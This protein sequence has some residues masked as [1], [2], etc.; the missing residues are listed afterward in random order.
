[1]RARLFV[2]GLALP[3]LLACPG[4]L[5]DPERFLTGGDAGGMACD[6]ENDI[7]K[8][9]CGTAGCHDAT[10]V[11]QGLDLA[12]TGVKTRLGSQLATCTS[13]AG[14]PLAAF[15]LVKVKPNPTCGGPMP[16]GLTALDAAELK[17][18]ED[19]L[20]ALDGGTP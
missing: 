6:V 2:L 7:F 11:A 19:Y 17:C 4:S 18:L 1:M 8:L 14:Q 20:A 12:T 3:A 9:K 16:L 13:A 15:L 5:V 10:T